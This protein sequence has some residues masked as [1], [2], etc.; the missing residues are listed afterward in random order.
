MVLKRIA[1]IGVIGIVVVS[2]S[3]SGSGKATQMTEADSNKPLTQ[4]EVQGV[5]T[6][7]CVSCHG[8]DGKLKGSGAADLSISTIPDAKILE[9]INK[10]NDKGMMPYEE[11]LSE[12]EREG[13]VTYV[14]SLR[15]K[16]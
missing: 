14:K 13:L 4:E 6:I 1:C 3:D 8:V 7:N 12:R 2:C 5:Y 15:N 11:M 9:T 10:G 16:D